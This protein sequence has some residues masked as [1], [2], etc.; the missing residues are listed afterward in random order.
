MNFSAT[1][2]YDWN[3]KQWHAECNPQFV[4][5]RFTIKNQFD[6]TAID[7]KNQSDGAPL[8]FFDFF[9]ET[10]FKLVLTLCVQVLVFHPIPSVNGIN[11]SHIQTVESNRIRRGSLC[12]TL[13]RMSSLGRRARAGLFNR[14]QAISTIGQQCSHL[15]RLPRLDSS[16]SFRESLPSGLKKSC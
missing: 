14:V 2:R 11:R 5:P 16:C 15:H 9:A 7:S 6:E 10:I 1:A 13:T 4:R 3:R 8:P 12:E